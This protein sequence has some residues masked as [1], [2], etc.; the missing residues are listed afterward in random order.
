MVTSVKE[1][2]ATNFVP[3]VTNARIGVPLMISSCFLTV[4][5]FLI[6][7][8]VPSTQPEETAADHEWH[9]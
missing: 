5:A 4:S 7:N 8:F 3:F 1:V 2:Q 9:S 6:T